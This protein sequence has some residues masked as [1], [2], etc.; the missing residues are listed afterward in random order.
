MTKISLLK[1]VECTSVDGPGFRTSVYCA[2]CV[3]RCPGCHNPQSWAIENGRWTDVEDI[4][5]VIKSDDLCNV[6][7]SGG[8]PMY[9]ARA[10]AELARMIHRDTDKDI[11]CFTGYT[12]DEIM[13]DDVKRELLSEVDVVVEGR[14]IKEL[15]D[16]DLLFRGSRNQRILDAKKSLAAGEPV[17][18]VYNPFPEFDELRISKYAV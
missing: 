6:T 11:W 18:Y 7:F 13:A 1:I 17:A 4:L 15:R 16:E 12:F 3:N 9:Q 8:D 14:Y 10:F 2:G 5:E